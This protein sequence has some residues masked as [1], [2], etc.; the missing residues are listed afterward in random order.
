MRKKHQCTCR[1]LKLTLI[2]LLCYFLQLIT[3]ESAGNRI[4]GRIQYGEEPLN[5]KYR[6][7]QAEVQIKQQGKE[8]Y[9]LKSTV[10]ED[11]EVIRAVFRKT[12]PLGKT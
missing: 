10:H 5:L 3:T 1:F 11:K 4:E 7:S 12:R 6:M 9:V 8:I 2:V